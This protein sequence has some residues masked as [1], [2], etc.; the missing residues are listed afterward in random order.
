MSC[1]SD[2]GSE[3][4][5]FQSRLPET[6]LPE[7]AVTVNCA[8]PIPSGKGTTQLSPQVKGCP[9]VPVI[10]TGKP[11]GSEAVIARRAFST[12]QPLVP[13]RSHKME[14]IVIAGGRAVAVAVGVK[15][16]VEDGVGVNVAVGEGVCVDVEVGVNVG[17]TVE[18]EGGNGVMVGGIGV[19]VANRPV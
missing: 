5:Y 11:C 12:H 6:V 3:A 9:A 13:Q 7:L 16:G 10:V 1:K 18:V 14:A 2:V 15:V 17:V 8:V 4:S 19:F